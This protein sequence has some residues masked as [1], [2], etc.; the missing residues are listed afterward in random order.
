MEIPS[1]A[2]HD[3]SSRLTSD[4]EEALKDVTLTIYEQLSDLVFCW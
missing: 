4:M 2:P 1:L 3:T